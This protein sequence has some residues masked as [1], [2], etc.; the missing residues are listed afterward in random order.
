MKN[1]KKYLNPFV[2]FLA[3]AV[4][5]VFAYQAF[6]SSSHLVWGDAPYY[7]AENMVELFSQPLAWNTRNDN[8]GSNQSL[9][10]WLFIPT[11]LYGLLS[12]IISFSNDTLIR[13]VFYFPAVLLAVSGCY[14]FLRTHT[15]NRISLL[16]GTLFY[17]LNSYF[18][19]VIDG[20]QIG[21]ALAYGLFPWVVYSCLQFL[22]VKSIKSYLLALISTLLIFN[23]DLRLA[24]LSLLLIMLIIISSKVLWSAK[25]LYL[26]AGIILPVLFVSAYWLLPLILQDGQLVQSAL[27][28]FPAPKLVDAL[29]LFQ[30]HF[31]L[32]Q[33]GTTVLPPFYY[34]IIPLLIIGGLFSQRQYKYYL[35]LFLFFA[36]LAKG[37][38][39]PFG[40]LYDFIEDLPLGFAFRDSAKFYVPL[41]LVA[42]LLIAGTAELISK[43]TKYAP[44]LLLAIYFY[45]LLLVYPAF[46]GGLTGVLT[47]N[48]NSDQEYQNL[49]QQLRTEKNTR[50]LWFPEK[51]PLAFSS[52]QV[53]ALAANT[54]Y[55]FRPFGSMI[56]GTYDLY[57]YLNSPQLQSWLRL[58]NIEYLFFPEDVRKKTWSEKELVN[59]QKFITFVN[60]VFL[61]EQ[62]IDLTFPAFKID[63]SAPRIFT[64]AKSYLVLGGD[65][66]Y[67]RLFTEDSNFKLENQGFIFL[68]DPR[69]DLST[70]KSI[71][72]ADADILISG[73]KGSD[74]LAMLFLK[75][76]LLSTKNVISAGWGEQSG[77]NYLQWKSELLKGGIRTYDFAADQ[78]YYSSVKDEKI[79]FQTETSGA[80]QYYLGL[81]TSASSGSADL[82]VQFADKD[83]SV[84]AKNNSQFTWQIFGPYQLDSGIK[85][86]TITNQGGFQAISGVGVVSKK[87]LTGARISVEELL[88]HFSI[89]AQVNNNLGY[90]PVDFQ[91]LNP[92]DY[93]LPKPYSHPWLVFSDRFDPKWQIKGGRTYNYPIYGMINGIYL[94]EAYGGGELNLYYSGQDIVNTGIK[95]S[96]VSVGFLIVILLYLRFKKR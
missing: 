28:S 88:R 82:R 27:L 38:N 81:R 85:M 92:A 53:P 37:S 11:F 65:E 95:I 54:L 96:L 15:K 8:F 47:K 22:E 12:Q 33:F 9:V 70:L 24:A 45:L 91:Q 62:K 56:D 84:K 32:N 80:G 1:L 94:P 2:L 6:F 77:D 71:R 79:S 34:A 64:V 68:E 55:Q 72:T 10:L 89:T 17:S 50:S 23:V 29:L 43:K 7:Y 4:P 16:L 25:T 57:G 36:F 83:I 48:L 5:L 20:G 35:I 30:P 44:A 46:T 74:D 60:N 90:E 40:E 58:L 14:L 93:K 19:L 42:S 67:Q 52:W 78:I 21:V 39:L 76:N 26:I 86:I 73:D 31:P 41:L 63:Q 61:S 69:V 51:S 87:E 66:I 13:I 49:Y 18:L 59:R 75:E 3:L